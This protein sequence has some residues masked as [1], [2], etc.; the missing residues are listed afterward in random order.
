MV[1]R[2]LWVAGAV[3]LLGTTLQ[4]DDTNNKL[5]ATI[6]GQF[7]D[8]KS[9]TLD[10][11]LQ[12]HLLPVKGSPVVT[13][14]VA[15]KV[16]SCDEEKDQ[17]G[18]SHYLEHLLFKGTDKLKPGDID[19]ATQRN[20]G[21]NN[22]YTSEDMTVYHFDFASDRWKQAL[23]I[24]ADRMRH[25][26]IDAK[27]E[28]EQE[29]GAVISELKGGE[30]RPWELEYKA[31]LPRLFDA[32]H[33]YSHPVIGDEKHVRG[34]SAEIIARYYDLW[35]H[36][37]N[38][39]III[40]GGFDADEAL[41]LVKK[42]FGTIP[43][44]DLPKRKQPTATPQ[45]TESV[46]YEFTSKF[47]AARLMI[48]FNTV[49]V[50]EKDD[51]VLDIV[52]SVLS[53]G[54]NG[55]LYKRLVQG[56]QMANAIGAENSA[57]RHPGWFGVQV[58]VLKGQDRRKAEAA[59]LEELA[60]LA[61]KP[62]AA[63]ELQRIQRRF[64]ASYV[65]GNESV[66]QLCDLLA[67]GITLKDKSYALDY[68][69]NLLKVTPAD[70]QAAAKKYFDPK[71]AV[72]VWTVPIDDAHPPK[73]SEAKPAKQNARKALHRE[74]PVKATGTELDLTKAKR[75]ELKN[76]VVLL[77][78]ENRRLPIVVV[79]VDVR[80]V[81]LREPANKSGLATL[82][83]DLLEEGTATLD[84]DKISDIIENTGGS[85]SFSSAGASLKMLTPD[86]DTG[87]KI[88]FDCLRNPAFPKD[89]LEQVRAQQLSVIADVETQPQNRANM[90]LKSAIYG[91]HPFGRSAQGTKDIVKALTVEDLKSFHKEAFR[92]D[93]MTIAAVGDFDAEA[94]AKKL[95]GYIGDWKA[96]P[97]K[98]YKVAVPP[99]DGKPGEIIL[100]DPT[101]AQTHVY[102]GHIGIT[103]DDPDYYTLQVMDNVLG[104]GPG[105]TDRLSSS[106][107][108]RQGL[109]YTVRA[110]ISDS[111]GTQP[112][113]FTG[114][115]GTF[116]NKFI[117]VREGFL[118]E[119]NRIRDEAATK[120]EVEDAKKYLTGSLAFTLTSNES[121]AGTLLAIERHKLGLDY[122][123]KYKAKIEAV[124]VEDVQ[125]AA[126]KHL[127][128]KKLTVAVC[129]PIGTDGLPLKKT[130]DKDK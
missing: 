82:M 50:G 87:L 55:R 106:L 28:F 103:R 99:K 118:K 107:R 80:D 114:Y 18:L 128:P 3:L 67:R 72:V 85:L 10:N 89:R 129:G 120:T 45:R 84:G 83:G 59:A 11:G 66:H 101:A 130:D 122:L 38:A 49:A 79:D 74:E 75:V 37:N 53:D 86:A 88:L 41:T 31:I 68:L 94:M 34:V 36:P 108:D 63:E 105:F 58:E 8:L 112:G 125:K 1:P 48:G 109:A 115:I 14:M 4:A 24:E 33:P 65:F 21:R 57:G 9:T 127:D 56:D 69:D 2:I 54:K 40:V 47:D 121:I 44:A 29:K 110:S 12:V 52:Q 119:F 20:G 23:E 81:R 27:H 16:G 78:L 73:T 100:S 123:A 19:R 113:T 5:L 70:V 42:L 90:A 26:K 104:V 98:E 77:L 61:E 60:K 15:Y 117:W 102:I 71:K 32:K 92:P 97:A 30:D 116:P 22:A 76:G 111:A 46:R 13:T 35:Y 7:K 91:D 25:T 17:T 95:E 6:Q 51:Y 62:I 64:L 126:K 96:E 43:N 39:A 124:T 93:A